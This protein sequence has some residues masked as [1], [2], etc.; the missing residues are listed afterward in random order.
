MLPALALVSGLMSYSAVK[1]VIE[2]KKLVYWIILILWAYG[3]VELVSYGGLLYLSKFRHLDYEPV[4]TIS[5]KHQ[6]FLNGLIEK[7]TNYNSYSP[8]LGWT[9]KNNGS[10]GLYKANSSAIRSDR[11]Y[12]IAPPPGVRRVSTFGDSFTHCD[13]VGNHDTWQA[14]MEGYDSSLEVLNFG[15]GAFGLDQAYLRYLEEGRQYQSGIVLIG[16]MSENVKRNVNTYRPFYFPKTGLPLAK[17]RFLLEGESLSFVPNPLKSLH[18]YKM[19]LLYPRDVLSQMGANDYFYKRRYTSNAFD[20]SPTIKLV[21]ILIQSSRK[22]LPGDEDIILNGYYNEN[23]EAFRVTTKIFDE[24]YST[25]INNQ[26]VPIVL[27]FPNR[28]D[29]IRKRRNKYKIYST[30]L[31]YFDSVGYRYIDLIEAFGNVD[32]EDL[33]AGHY[34]PLANELIARY[35]LDHINNMSNEK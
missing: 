13:D 12:S 11:E 21:T 17:P 9:I 5:T 1:W 24:F 10:S 22:S 15:V 4:D 34:T 18:D 27:V 16:F 30:L 35:I 3:F 7:K 23:S 2:M 26:S 25:A 20:W 14:V 32:V 33:F 28:D 8:T 29:L 31:A 19:L 6:E